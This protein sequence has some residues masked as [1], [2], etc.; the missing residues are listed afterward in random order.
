MES[1][2]QDRTALSRTDGRL[3]METEA[4]GNRRGEYLQPKVLRQGPSASPGPL[5]A[6]AVPDGAI[7]VPAQHELSRIQKARRGQAPLPKAQPIS[8]SSRPAHASV[9]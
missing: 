6:S 3:A 8:P 2:N 4:H 9:A 1:A 5:L 7:L